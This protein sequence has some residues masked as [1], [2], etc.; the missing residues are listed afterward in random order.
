MATS[1]LVKMGIKRKDMHEAETPA[2]TSEKDYDK[3]IVRPELHLS[4][5]HAKMMGAEDLKKGDR[6]QQ[7]VQWVVGSHAKE[8]ENGKPPHYRMTLCLDKAGDHSECK[9]DDD[10][11]GEAVD[12]GSG[13]D[14]SP[15]MAYIAGR[16]KPESD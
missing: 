14:D 2:V 3:E 11:E 9:G 13:K 10:E 8:E 5:E 7:T 6:V 12:D 16:A 4:G 1:K 15:A